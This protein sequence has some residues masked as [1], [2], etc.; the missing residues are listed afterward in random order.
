MRIISQDGHADLPYERTTLCVDGVL[1]TARCD[2]MQYLMGKYSTEEKAIRAMEMCR[3]KY[4][5]YQKVGTN[6]VAF[7]PPKAFQFPAE[8]EV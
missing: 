4:L 6:M 8:E 3:G 1:V 7:N 2:G 5:R